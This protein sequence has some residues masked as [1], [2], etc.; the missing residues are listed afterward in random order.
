MYTYFEDFQRT[1]CASVQLA[2]NRFRVRLQ[3]RVTIET[4][5]TTLGVEMMVRYVN[6]YYMDIIYQN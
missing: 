4:G 3:L 1:E 6:I 5:C 2:L